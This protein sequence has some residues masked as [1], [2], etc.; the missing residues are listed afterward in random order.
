MNKY[1]VGEKEYQD[2]C[3]SYAIQE[4]VFDETFLDKYWSLIALGGFVLLLAVVIFVLS[5]KVMRLKKEISKT[6]R[7]FSELAE[8][9]TD[10]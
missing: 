5:S 3:G 1:I 7:D 4:D 2:L 9:E 10:L 6:E 8:T